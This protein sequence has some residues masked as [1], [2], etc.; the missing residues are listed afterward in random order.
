MRKKLKLSKKEKE[1]ASNKKLGGNKKTKKRR[2]LSSVRAKLIFSYVLLSAV[3]I[4]SLLFTI[5]S[6]SALNGIIE[7]DGYVNNIVNTIGDLLRHQGVYELTG[8]ED[9]RGEIYNLLTE[10]QDQVQK[11][12]DSEADKAT[13]DSV[14]LIGIHI[15][16]YRS[17]FGHYITSRTTR[18]GIVSTMNENIETSKAAI[19]DLS[20]LIEVQI[21]LSES[22]MGANTSVDINT[23]YRILST[24][25]QSEQQIYEL[26]DY[27]SEYLLEGEK[28]S[29]ITL[30]AK[31]ENL[32]T[33]LDELETAIEPLGVENVVPTLRSE[34]ESY[35]GSSDRLYQTDVNMAEQSDNLSE[36]ADSVR[37]EGGSIYDM[38]SGLVQS[39]SASTYQTAYTSL[40]IGIIIALLASIIVFRSISKPLGKLTLELL[41]ATEEKDLTKQIQLKTNDEFKQL[42]EALNEFNGR[43]H[44]MMKEV[45]TDAD[46][47]ETLASDVS[48]QVKRL[49]ENI[50][51]IS[52]SIEELSASMEETSAASEQIDSSAQGVDQMIGK[53][54]EK[55]SD[56]QNYVGDIRKRAK[57]VKE[58]S[59]D[60]RD[61]ATQLY[62]E[63]K[64]LL[65]DSIE[66]SKAVE[67]INLLSNS[68]LDIA[69]QTNLL[70]LNAAIEAARAG[71]AG[72]GF[73]VVAEE[74]R[75]LAS[76]S[77]D[78]ANEIQAVTQHVIRSVS[79]LKENATGLITFIEMN[80][81]GD[82]QSMTE[83]GEQY[84]NDANVLSDMFADLVETMQEMKV[85]IKDVTE[86]I[87]NIAAT[88]NESAKGVSEVAENIGDIVTVSDQV[89][90]ETDKVNSN[91]KSLKSYVSAFKI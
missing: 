54:V 36:L 77:Q 86:T 5:Q 56:G 46:G 52:A 39:I 26:K 82:Y 33:Q 66:R 68:I 83:M 14:T 72:K 48:L 40:I 65:S 58:S 21:E 30:N 84:D 20:D 59:E 41:A 75:K 7:V 69:E 6:I 11:V 38:Q 42:A 9:E 60:A 34:I 73:S 53:V 25:Q 43:I 70:A 2:N 27:T 1:A 79:D 44:D 28:S 15:G 51:N 74:I 8:S 4:V 81:L 35:L 10:I 55:A 24:V 23:L 67:K 29:L 62:N 88:I 49:N 47:L 50:E 91:S 17:E 63:S 32:F 78:S 90:Q 57:S 31:A 19:R 64:Q 37:A 89:A 85:S 71:E 76:T 12:M 13:K 16:N 3:I 45:D 18:D 22:G 61:I 80:V 87:G